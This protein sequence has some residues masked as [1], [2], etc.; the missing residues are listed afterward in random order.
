[1]RQSLCFAFMALLLCCSQSQA[2]TRTDK[3]AYN[4]ILDYDVP[5]SPAFV[6]L[7]VSPA[8][9]YGASSLKPVMV[10]IASKLLTGDKIGSGI[11]FDFSPYLTLW[12]AGTHDISSF[13]EW[14][15]SFLANLQV[16][17]AT[18]TPASDTNVTRFGVGVRAVFF[19]DHDMLRHKETLELIGKAL[20]NT[21][22]EHKPIHAG[23]DSPATSD[24][25]KNTAN[26]DTT[27]RDTISAAIR[28]GHSEELKM[29][30]AKQRDAVAQQ[31]G[32]ALAV[33]GG[34]SGRYSYLTNSANFDT[35]RVW[36]SYTRYRIF[37]G[38]DFLSTA[39]STISSSFGWSVGVALRGTSDY[40]MADAEL[41]VRSETMALEGG[42][43]LEVKVMTGLRAVLDLELQKASKDSHTYVPAVKTSLKWNTG[44]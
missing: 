10:D 37:G 5:E 6:V 1:M 23:K 22:S 2:Q 9:V 14:T 21:T 36:A 43:K 17:L 33:A 24:A 28:Q 40:V 13:N 41:A 3:S 35:A 8:K 29:V 11:A 27:E 32:D 4:F 20:E 26:V 38:M 16:S 34:F 39:Q 30:Y 31:P 7:G 44:N 19:D 15:K 42:A 18:L 25:S 12:N